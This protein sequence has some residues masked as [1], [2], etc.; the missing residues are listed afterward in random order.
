[1]TKR[2]LLA[3]VLGG[4]TIFLWS[5][6]S[7]IKLGLG[8]AGMKGIPNEAAVLAVMKE[9]IKEPALYFFP[10]MDESQLKT[11][12]DWEVFKQ[13]VIAGPTGLMI[14]HPTGEDPLSPKQLLTEL[15]ADIVFSLI[16]ALVL[17]LAAGSLPSYLARAGVVALL[18]LVGWLDIHISFWNWYGFPTSYTLAALVDMV[19]GYA[20]AGL[21]MAWF[22]KKE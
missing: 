9:N 17:S 14:Y 3:G 15:G 2:I 11:D 21:V 8:S 19:V 12:A 1:M 10:W 4:L 7:H 18:G 6:V 13:K 20:L 22:I 16:L 5:A